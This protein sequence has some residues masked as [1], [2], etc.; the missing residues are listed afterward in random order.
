MRSDQETA[1]GLS[2]SVFAGASSTITATSNYSYNGYSQTENNPAIQGSLDYGWDNGFYVG[3][4]ASNVD[5]ALDGADLEWDAYL[6]KYFELN[7]TFGLDTGF[8][9]YTYH[10]DDAASD[11]NYSEIYTQLDIASKV[12]TS[13]VRLAYAWD[14]FGFDVKHLVASVAHTFKLAEDQHVKFS[15]NRSM[16][17]DKTKWAWDGGKSYNHYRVSYLL[18]WKGFAF[19][20]SVEDTSMNLDESQARIIFTV[21]RTFNF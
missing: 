4:F 12:G 13:N 20:V 19:N 21:A 14:Y 8:S 17:Y 10:G 3:T 6:G 16:S 9:H 7:D 5:F 11:L 2:A 18:D 15:Y 1:L